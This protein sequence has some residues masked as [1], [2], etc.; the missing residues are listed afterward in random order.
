MTFTGLIDQW[1]NFDLG[2]LMG[3]GSGVLFNR[4]LWFEDGGTVTFNKDVEL[5]FQGQVVRFVPAGETFYVTDETTE[6]GVTLDDGNTVVFVL[7]SNPGYYAG[8]E[9]DLPLNAF[10]GNVYI[11]TEEDE[12]PENPFIGLDP[13][14]EIVNFV[15]VSTTRVGLTN[16]D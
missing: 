12:Q 3:S 11:K 5:R 13:E 7:E 6:Y 2:E 1:F 16:Y 8:E 15:V 9:P 4:V 14:L 10:P